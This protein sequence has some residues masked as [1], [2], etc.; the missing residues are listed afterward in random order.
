MKLGVALLL[1]AQAASADVFDEYS[2]TVRQQPAAQLFEAACRA[3]PEIPGDLGKGDFARL[4]S[5]LRANV[6]GKASLLTT[7]ELLVAATGHPLD[8][9]TFR[10]H[11]RRRYVERAGAP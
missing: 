11:L 2:D 6:H 9:D 1:V 7:E 10:R 3:E 8:A 4:V 5:W